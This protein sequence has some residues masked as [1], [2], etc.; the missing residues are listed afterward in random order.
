MGATDLIT[1]GTFEWTS[2]T[3]FGAFDAWGTYE[4]ATGA[5]GEDQSC[6][7]VCKGGV[8][9][10]Y[11]GTFWIDDDCTSEYPF[12]CDPD[13]FSLN[14]GTT[15]D[16]SFMKKLEAAEAVVTAAPTPADPNPYADRRLCFST[17]QTWEDA[18]SLCKSVG[19]NLITIHNQNEFDHLSETAYFSPVAADFG[20]SWKCL[21]A[22]WSDSKVEGEYEWVSK[23][24]PVWNPVWGAFEAGNGAGDDDDCVMICKSDCAPGDTSCV[25]L[26][27]YD[28]YDGTFLAD[29]KCSDEYSFCCDG[30]AANYVAEQNAVTEP[31]S[32]APKDDD[33]ATIAALGAVAGIATVTA[34]V[35][36]FIAYKKTRQYAALSSGGGLGKGGAMEL[37]N[38]EL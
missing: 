1:E 10:G 2:G 25:D 11:S 20:L 8:V 5:P 16:N 37:T 12:C 18:Q 9:E 33:K 29:T 38:Y 14:S 21:W 22:G 26:S 13:T 3:A 24:N 7:Q 23:E 4:P 35:S 34:M 6:G 30:I 36:G 19:S 15:D 28:N 27:D 17:K 31:P 32:P